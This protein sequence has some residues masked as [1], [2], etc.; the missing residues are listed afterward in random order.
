MT[1]K[2]KVS[3]N[4]LIP[5]LFILFAFTAFH[6]C[7]AEKYYSVQVAASKTPVDIGQFIKKNNIGVEITEIKSNDWIRYFAGHFDNYDS[8]SVFAAKLLR[9]PG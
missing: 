4:Y 1:S 9:E 6:P 5:F 2:R 7:S 8:A 3:E